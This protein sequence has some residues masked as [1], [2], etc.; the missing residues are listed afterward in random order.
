M[1]TENKRRTQA[2]RSAESDRQMFEAATQLIVERGPEKTTLTDIG[3]SAGYSRGLAAYRYG[4]K[5]VFFSALIAHLHHSWCEELDL[6]IGDSKGLE[7]VLLAVT[8]LKN[9]VEARPDEL[10]AMFNLYYYSIDHHSE[11]TQQLEKIHVS[12]RKQAIAWAEEAVARKEAHPQVSRERFAEQY[13][14]L[15]FGAIYQW[16]VSPARVALPELLESCKLSLQAM[17]QI[18]ES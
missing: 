13:C 10:R 4:T 15:I 3:I 6:T 11:M 9:Y 7:T 2:E 17:L 18:P 1:A 8:A 14:A 12:Q 5:D 16:L